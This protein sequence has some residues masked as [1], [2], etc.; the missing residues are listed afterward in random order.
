MKFHLMAS[1]PNSPFFDDLR[2]LYSGCASSPF[3][4]ILLKSGNVTSYRSVQNFADLRLGAR[5][6]VTELIARKA[7]HDDV[8]ALELPVQ[9]LEATGTEA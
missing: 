1:V 7:E 3:T 8:P 6:L 9:R 2:S 5:F 4:L